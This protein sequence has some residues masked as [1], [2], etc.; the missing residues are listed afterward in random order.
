MELKQ[1]DHFSCSGRNELEVGRGCVTEM[2]V[3]PLDTIVVAQARGAG[4]LGLAGGRGNDRRRCS[5]EILGR[6][7]P[8][9]LMID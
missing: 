8:W 3:V 5:K 1:K 2:N 7:S 9:E 6:R 4:N